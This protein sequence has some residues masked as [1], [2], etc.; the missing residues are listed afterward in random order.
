METSQGVKTV[1][2]QQAE[3]GVRKLLE[4]LQTVEEGDLKGSQGTGACLC[5][6]PSLR[7]GASGWRAS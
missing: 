4:S 3:A 5:W 7:W 2:I 1:L 6:K